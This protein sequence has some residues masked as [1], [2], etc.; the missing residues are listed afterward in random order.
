[1][2]QRDISTVLM[3]IVLLLG[4]SQ[5]FAADTK[6]AAPA[7][8]A[9]KATSAKGLASSKKKATSSVKLVDIN[10]AKA[11]ELTKLPGITEADAVKII[12]GRPYSSKADL[13]VRKVIDAGAYENLKKMIIARQ[14]YKDAARNAALYKKK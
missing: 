7:P 2:K 13:T 6:A 3:A 1:M 5:C 11:A 8:A 9:S 12:A 10:S 14:P 4:S